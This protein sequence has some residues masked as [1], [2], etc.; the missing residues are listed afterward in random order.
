[1]A[2]AR[3]GPGIHARR[4]AGARARRAHRGARRR[5]RARPVRALCGG[6]PWIRRPHH[7]PRVPSLQHGAHGG[8]HRG[9]PRL[10]RGRI[11][12]ARGAHGEGR[13][14]RRAVPHSGRGVSLREEVGHARCSLSTP[15]VPLR[16]HD[17][18]R[19][20]P[21]SRIYGSGAD[22]DRDVGATWSW[23]TLSKMRFDDR[24]W[25][26]VA[27]DGMAHVIWNDGSGVSHAT[28]RDRGVTW[29]VGARI[30][31]QGGSSHLA[32][33]PRGEVAVRIVPLSASGNKFDPG[34][35]LIAVSTDGGTTWQKGPPPGQ[36]DWAPPGT[37]GVLPRWVEPLAWDGEGRLYALWTDTTGVWLAR[38]ADR[39]GVWT[40]W[41]VA[42]S[43]ATSDYPDRVARGHGELAATWFSGVGKDLEWHAA[44]LQGREDNAAPRVIQSPPL[45]IEVWIPPAAQGDSLYHGTGGEYLGMTFLQDGGLGV[46]SPIQ[47]PSA[48]RLGFT[49]WR[50]D[51]R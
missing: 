39:G 19:L 51:A 41:R 49:W 15:G 36:R 11:G 9:A 26:A 13:A 48:N 37:S 27:P 34:V 24:P 16:P 20:H 28:S 50:F 29:R 18:R 31:A 12:H 40:S 4:P 25:V 8:L 7:D 17:A 42:G 14:L 10:A 2:E 43:R 5:D 47:N 23:T 33:G 3:A 21:W 32:V 1:M 38:S 45:P 35:E 30:H 44:R 22:T 6:G 46:T